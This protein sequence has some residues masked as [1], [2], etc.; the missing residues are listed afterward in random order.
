MVPWSWVGW[1]YQVCFQLDGV[2]SRW[3]YLHDPTVSGWP[4]V[5]AC[6]SGFKLLDIAMPS[7]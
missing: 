6:Y 4:L 7:H 5:I 2:D 1:G 3:V